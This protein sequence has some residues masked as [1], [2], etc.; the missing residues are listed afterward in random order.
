[1]TEVV[2][3]VDQGTSA[4]K[5]MFVSASGEAVGFAS[6]A[7]GRT[8]PRPGWVEQDPRE[9][10][11]SVLAAVEQL[12]RAQVQAVGICSQRESVLFWDRGTGRP[13]TPCVGWQCTRGAELCRSLRAGGA[14]PLVR[15]LTGLPLDAM[16]SASKLRHLLDADP[17]LRAAALSGNACAGTV[18]SWLAWNLTG[19]ELHVSDAGN[20]SRTLLFDIQ[21]LAWSEQL[22]E[23]FD[24]P[25][26]CLPRVVP[27]GGL[28]G[29][30]V[31]QGAVPRAPLAALAADSHAALYGL[32]CLRK[33][34][35]KATYGTGTSLASPTGLEPARSKYGLATSVA[36]LRSTPTFVLEGNVFS[37]GATVEW[38]AK[39][40][41]LQGPSALEE[42]ARTV[43]GAGGI[44]LVPGF[45]GLGAPHWCSEARGE[46]TGLTF[47]TGR[48][49]LAWAALE[50]TAFQVADLVSALEKDT[51]R[52]LK[53]LH[54]DGGA[55][56]NDVLMQLQADLIG[57]PIVRSEAR[58]ASALGAAFLA[59]LATRFFDSEDD[60]EVIGQQGETIEPKMRETEREERLAAWHE[61]VYRAVAPR[62]HRTSVG[63][64]RWLA[65]ARGG[66]TEHRG[67]TP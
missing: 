38:V 46:I 41:G 62:Q 3:A 58:D 7:V 5:V 1:V 44:H 34:T 45:A 20:A 50:S 4:T 24:V 15:E 36:W 67:G 37:S 53:E 43:P 22:L 27:S 56:G 63:T 39:L 13:L 23:L 32:G 54:V 26:A 14:E 8:Y 18:D 16:Y 29:E 48:A 9:I 49:E 11:Q 55:T 64:N 40:L 51:G 2:L 42:L 31:P 19:G 59:G 30:T 28:I 61:A 47:A 52:R 57:C 12:P 33:G 17:S 35:A 25:G 60:I 10:W 21:R 6:V 65:G 66:V